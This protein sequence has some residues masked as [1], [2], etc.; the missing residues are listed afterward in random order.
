LKKIAIYILLLI[1]A[2][3][4]LYPFV[5]MIL[6][7]IKPEVEIGN[8][9]L[10][11]SKFT[12]FHY[13]E[14]FNKI[15]IVRSF[16]NSLIV[17][18]SVTVSVLVFGS[19]VGYAL[20]RLKYAGR[21]LIFMIVLFTMM[22]PFQITM[23]PTYV[24]MVKFQWID[25]YLALIAPWFVTALGILLF[26]QYFKS[27]PQDLVDAA[28][29]DGCSELQILFRIFWPLSKPT[30]I[31][32]ALITFMH[33]WNDVLWPLIVIRDRNLMTMPQLVTILKT[34]G[35]AESQLGAQLA[36]ATMLAI[37]VVI[38]YAFFQRYFIESMARSGLKG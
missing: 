31:T 5:W 33:S 11:S 8:L 18:V 22:I 27:I 38:A 6:A 26:R 34:G 21:D 23:I 30:L 2:L 4:F 35:Q 10:W 1:G 9:G 12:F 36:A 20:S 3:L 29:I 14:V 15:P 32:V 17:S 28:R 25:S 24:L 7:T 37:P 19:M 13:K 16:L